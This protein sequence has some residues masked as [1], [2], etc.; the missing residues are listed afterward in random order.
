M[1]KARKAFYLT[2]SVLA[3]VGILFVDFGHPERMEWEW[4]LLVGCVVVFPVF[5]LWV[6][7]NFRFPDERKENGISTRQAFAIFVGSFALVGVLG[8]TKALMKGLFYWNDLTVF[9][10]LLILFGITGLF[11]IHLNQKL[12]RRAH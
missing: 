7:R 6:A 8:L 4:S 9:F 10:G 3:V 11:A 2:F 12:T 5:A 1:T